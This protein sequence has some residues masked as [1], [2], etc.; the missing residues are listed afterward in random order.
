MNVVAGVAVLLIP[1]SFEFVDTLCTAA[2]LGFLC[3]VGNKTILRQ[4][5]RDR[6]SSSRVAVFAGVRNE[7]EL[8]CEA[9]SLK[10]M[11]V[12][13]VPT[14]LK[15]DGAPKLGH[16]SSRCSSQ[17]RDSLDFAPQAS[18]GLVRARASTNGKELREFRHLPQ[19]FLDLERTRARTNGI[20]RRATF[21]HALPSRSSRQSMLSSI[22]S[23]DSTSE[24]GVSRAPSVILHWGIALVAMTELVLSAI[25]NNHTSDTA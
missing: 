9:E 24:P 22:S 21:H 25:N 1:F 7:I 15:E 2:V 11:G 6:V 23:R 14:G 16:Y 17:R 3:E 18:P 4:G 5:R 10:G 13:V 19:A 12:A 20:K 8:E